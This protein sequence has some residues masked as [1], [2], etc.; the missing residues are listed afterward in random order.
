MPSSDIVTE[1]FLMM[2]CFPVQLVVGVVGN[3]LNLMVLLSKGMRSKTNIILAS[4][5]LADILFLLFMVPHSLMYNKLF[6]NNPAFKTFIVYAN[7]HII[8]IVNMCSFASAW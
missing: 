4:V 3:L 7:Y 5:A 6:T 2:Y 8:G 1:R